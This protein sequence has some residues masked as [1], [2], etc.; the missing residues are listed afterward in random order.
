[1]EAVILVGLQASGKSSFCRERFFS[2]HVRINLDMLK[3]RYRELCML[4][5]CLT[6]T[7]PFVVDNTN[8]SRIER[9]RYISLARAAQFR[10]VGYYF[11]SLLE[12]CIARNSQ[13]S[14][15]EQIPLAGV[16]GTASRLERPHR[17]EGFDELYY[18]AFDGCGG[19]DVKEWADEV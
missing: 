2:T 12:D 1:M 15:R 6:T 9:Q 4:K 13:R 11:Q 5:A 3:T 18:V 8:A 17:D 19:F 16:R 7:Q 10:V 14:G